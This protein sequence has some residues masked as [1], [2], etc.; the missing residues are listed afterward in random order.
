MVSYGVINNIKFSFKLYTRDSK[1]TDCHKFLPHLNSTYDR[2]V[3][4]DHL[5][6]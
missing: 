2:E 4:I 5:K 3:L 1:N 6:I